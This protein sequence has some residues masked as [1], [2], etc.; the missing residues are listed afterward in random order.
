VPT[1]A[2]ATLSPQ[3]LASSGSIASND[4]TPPASPAVATPIAAGA[5]A[6]SFGQRGS[7]TDAFELTTFAEPLFAQLRGAAC[8][9][10]EHVVSTLDPC[11]LRTGELRAHFSDGASSSFFCRSVDQTLVVKTV[12][13]AEVE[14]LVRLL[15]AYTQHLLTQPASLLCRIYGCFGLKLANTSRVYFLLMGNVFPIVDPGP[16]SETYDLKGSTV[17]RRARVTKS[18][19]S[20]N[21]DGRLVAKGMLFQDVEF[22]QAY[23]RGLPASDPDTLLRA[24][25]AAS[26]AG[27]GGDVGHALQ[28]ERFADLTAGI[29]RSKAIVDQLQRDVTLLAAQSIMDY[30]LLINIMPITDL[31][32]T[33][34]AAAPLLAGDAPLPTI[35]SGE[36]SAAAAA[37]A[38]PGPSPSPPPDAALTTLS[39]N[40]SSTLSLAEAVA[41]CRVAGGCAVSPAATGGAAAAAADA[42]AEQPCHMQWAASPHTPV[43]DRALVQHLARCSPL[44]VTAVALGSSADARAVDAVGGNEALAAGARLHIVGSTSVASSPA[45]GGVHPHQHAGSGALSA[46]LGSPALLSIARLQPSEGSASPRAQAD[47]RD[48][49]AHASNAGNAGSD[50]P[51]AMQLPPASG[52]LALSRG[53]SAAAATGGTANAAAATDGDAVEDTVVYRQRALLQ[54]GVIDMLQTYDVGKRMEHTLKSLRYAVAHAQLGGDADISAVDPGRY[55]VRFMDMASRIF[56]PAAASRNR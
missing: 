7:L 29:A 46:K 33:P 56:L 19:V 53:G 47:A 16:T 52:A 22:R 18:L 32:V 8:V 10:V 20:R 39:F 4:T 36:A 1:P 38:E 2:S 24:A 26:A 41:M 5:A 28:Q 6:A 21:E 3:L 31:G 30:S 37:A 12:S 44:S 25:V 23:P 17:G 54:L 49:A 40:K 43:P 9:T 35:G 34:A 48:T 55:A 11:L 15:P 50:G 27:S 45:L 14:V 51:P 13:A 42:G